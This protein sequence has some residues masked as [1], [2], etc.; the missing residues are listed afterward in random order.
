M[1]YVYEWYVIDTGEIFYVGKGTRNRY[2]VRKHN[3]FFDDFIKRYECSSRI[4]KTFENEKDA[5]NYEYERVY[6]LKKEQQCVC[7]IN[8]GGCGGTQACWTDEK[9]KIYSEKNVMK[10]ENQRKR[11]S[12]N[13]PM[14]NK[15]V[16][17]QVG[18]KHRKG[19]MINGV[20][21]DSVKLGAEYIGTS[22]IYLSN[23][24]KHRNGICKG[25]KCEYGNQ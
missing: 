5:F 3:K 4:I 21:F 19:V 10:S 8:D 9:R 15:K 1:F 11:M 2:K 22:D 20:Y 13:N 18:K 6:E 16:A 12:L 25:F 23:C 24:I 17:E 14:K 7:N